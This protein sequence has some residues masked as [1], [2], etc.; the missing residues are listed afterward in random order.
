MD[1][2]ILWK[3]I[4]KLNLSTHKNKRSTRN[5]KDLAEKVE[6]QLHLKKDMEKRKCLLGETVQFK[7]NC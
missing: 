5:K 6:N 7:E 4:I 2:E 1:D 3:I